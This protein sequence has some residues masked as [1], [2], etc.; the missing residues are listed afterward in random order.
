[1][2]EKTVKC[3]IV[4]DGATGKTCMLNT[5]IGGVFPTV[6]VP[7]VFDIHSSTVEVEEE[8][9][10]KNVTLNLHDTAGQEDYDRLRPLEYPGTDVVLI[11]FSVVGTP[12]FFKCKS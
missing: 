8:G 9:E 4:G 3:V 10:K 7:T 2:R 12:I 11:C 1:M 6:Y 5:Y